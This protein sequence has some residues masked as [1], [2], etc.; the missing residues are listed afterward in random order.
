MVLSGMSSL[1]QMQDNL[2]FMV[3]PKPLT[4]AELGAID[5]VVEHFRSLN[6]IPCTGCRYCTDGCPMGILIP[7]IF[8]CLNKYSQFHD[9]NQ[10]R[11]YRTVLTKEHAKA[12]ECLKCGMC[13]D[14]CPQ[15]LQIRDLLE[16][17]VELFEKE[18]DD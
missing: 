18:K 5:R 2:R 4:E 14:S 16:K 12:S 8:S 17:A 9:W 1:E 11:Y 3:E 15:G 13:E 10:P 6:L 7:D